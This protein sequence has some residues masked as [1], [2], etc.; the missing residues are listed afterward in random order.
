MKGEKHSGDY[1]PRTAKSEYKKIAQQVFQLSGR[2]GRVDA[3]SRPLL[4]SSTSVTG[5]PEV[6]GF[7]QSTVSKSELFGGAYSNISTFPF[8]R[9]LGK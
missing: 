5:G 6:R 8:R 1:L 9:G 3:D 2:D 4:A 7:G